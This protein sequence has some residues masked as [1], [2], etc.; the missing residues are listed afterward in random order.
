MDEF[1][2][3]ELSLRIQHRCRRATHAA[4]PPTFPSQQSLDI[5][6]QGASRPENR[7]AGYSIASEERRHAASRDGADTGRPPQ[8]QA[9]TQSIPLL[10]HVFLQFFGASV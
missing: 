7:L 10:R 5:W 3:E 2:L 4:P 1:H 6:P 9:D 8:Y